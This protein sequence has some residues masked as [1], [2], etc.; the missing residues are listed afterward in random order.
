MYKYKAKIKSVYDGDTCIAVVDLGFKMN[1]E[2]RL[3][4]SGIDAPELRKEERED[5]IKSRDFLRSL[6]L[7]KTVIIKTFRDKQEKYG[8]YLAQIF[9]DE[10][11]VSI[12][13]IMVEKGYAKVSKE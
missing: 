7:G 10:Y 9:V 3:R 2:V 13:Q 12:N 5:G 1:Y 11:P 6:I 4:L 8:R